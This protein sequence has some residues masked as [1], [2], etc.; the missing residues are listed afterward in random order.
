MRK[1]F[2]E[3]NDELLELFF[4]LKVEEAVVYVEWGIEGEW[5][6]FCI[7]VLAKESSFEWFVVTIF[8]RRKVCELNWGVCNWR[9]LRKACMTKQKRTKDILSPW[10]IPV[11][12]LISVNLV[13]TWFLLCN[14]CIAFWLLWWGQWGIHTWVKFC[15]GAGDVLCQ[16]LLL[17]PQRGRILVCVDSVE[18]ALFWLCVVLL[19]SLCGQ[20]E[21]WGWF[22]LVV[23]EFLASTTVSTII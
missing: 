8:V 6:S 21:R 7:W 1:V 4:S 17:N 9:V 11:V 20:I 16:R 2:V 22:L 18:V 14:C 12:L 3:I 10:W 23:W 13:P 15:I 19:G 5:S